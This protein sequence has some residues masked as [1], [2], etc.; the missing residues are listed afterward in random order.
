M[1]E[2]LDF[3]TS[4]GSNGVSESHGV[5]KR[6]KVLILYSQAVLQRVPRIAWGIFKSREF[7]MEE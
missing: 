7:R 2:G 6:L 4:M 5:D 3:D 1:P